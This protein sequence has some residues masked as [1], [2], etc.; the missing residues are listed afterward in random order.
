[1]TKSKFMRVAAI[2]MAA[3]LLTTCAISGT[4][5]KY[6]TSGNSADSAK[7]AKWGVTVTGSSDAFATEYST[8][9]AVYEGSVSVSAEEKVVA[10]GTAGSLTAFTITG[11]PEVAVRV[12]Y[13]VNSIALQGWDI[14][15]P[16]DIAGEYCPLVVT[17]NGTEY[18]GSTYSSVAEFREAIVT[19]IEATTKEYEPNTD[20][21]G[22]DA[23]D[24][25]AISWAWAF[26][27]ATGTDAKDTALGDAAAAG[28][29]ARIALNVSCT[30]TQI[31]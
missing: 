17:I 19:A 14:P 16:T 27:G 29:A 23:T 9:D 26:E 7:V 2:L 5:A 15:P 6:V 12:S 21:S 25:L 8:D 28:S 11:T 3:V 1:M 31:D 10:P 4:F 20:L 13:K 22:V 24:G 18:D 30:V